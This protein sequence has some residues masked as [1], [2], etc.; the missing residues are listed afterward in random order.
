[1]GV[2]FCVAVIFRREEILSY[3]GDAGGCGCEEGGEV[4]CHCGVMPPVGG[5]ISLCNDHSI[6]LFILLLISDVATVS[7]CVMNGLDV[8]CGCERILCAGRGG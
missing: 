1:V 5:N 8:S 4:R 7:R 6:D 2:V 3:G